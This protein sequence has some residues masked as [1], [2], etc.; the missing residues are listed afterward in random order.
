MKGDERC[1]T[2]GKEREHAEEIENRAEA[3]KGISPAGASAN[4]VYQDHAR[5]DPPGGML[6][7][8]IPGGRTQLYDLAH[9][10]GPGRASARPARIPYRGRASDGSADTH[11]RT[12][13]WGVVRDH[14]HS[15][16]GTTDTKI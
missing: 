8:R 11:R 12:V 16:S 3:S 4:P 5:S 14:R 1:T 15:R 13:R 10:S 9:S 2:W 6:V 7:C